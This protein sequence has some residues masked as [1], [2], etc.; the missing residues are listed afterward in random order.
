[1][2]HPPTVHVRPDFP[3]L[4][5]ITRSKGVLPQL[6]LMREPMQDWWVGRTLVDV[7]LRVHEWLSDAAAGKLVKS[8]DPYEPLVIVNENPPVEL[9]TTRAQ[10]ECA[11]YDGLWET[12]SCELSP[13]GRTEKHFRVG[14]G[15][16]PTIVIHQSRPQLTA[17][18]NSPS[19]W[20]D[21]LGLI[22]EIGV[23]AKRLKYW[24]EKKSASRGRVLVVV[25]VRRP[26]S[27]LGRSDAE[28]WAAFDIHTMPQRNRKNPS[29]LM[30]LDAPTVTSHVVLESLT[31]SLSARVSGWI[32]GLCDKHVVVIGAGAFGSVVAVTLLRWLD[33]R[34]PEN[35][36]YG[37]LATSQDFYPVVQTIW[38]H[39]KIVTKH[40]D[41]TNGTVSDIR[42]AER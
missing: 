20:E 10:S 18:T 22:S 32:D 16:V 8:D 28:E 13:E 21:V 34:W 33:G 2:H 1:M 29:K 27:V 41:G 35:A 17:W 11:K 38:K 39:P 26:K 25:G 15:D 5:H 40:G 14:N 7:V 42:R 24:M 36:S 9:D 6:C 30:N 12:S 19:T 31:P 37:V 3:S 4:P 23:D